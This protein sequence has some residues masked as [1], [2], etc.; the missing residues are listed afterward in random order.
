MKKNIMLLFLSDIKTAKDSRAVLLTRYDDVGEVAAT[1]ESAMRKLAADLGEERLDRLFV[2]ATDK[3][4]REKVPGMDISHLEFFWQRLQD[5]FPGLEKITAVIPYAAEA[6]MDEALH[7]VLLVAGELR[8][9]IEEQPQGDEILLHADTTGGMRHANMMIVDVLRLLEYSGVKV[10]HIYYSLYSERRVDEVNGIYDLLGVTSGAE[11]FV[12]FGSVKALQDYFT[13]HKRTPVI[14]ALLSA[15]EGFAEE[16]KLC[17]HGRFAAAVEKLRQALESFRAYCREQGDEALA[18]EELL[19]AQL[20]PRIYREYAPLL[21]GE[22]D[23]RDEVAWCLNHDYI[24]QAL[25]LYVEGIPDYLFGQ[26]AV[27]FTPLGEKAITR[28]WKKQRSPSGLNF[29][30]LTQFVPK[31]LLA[32]KD[33]GLGILQKSLFEK[34]AYQEDCLKK[35]RLALGKTLRAFMKC[36]KDDEARAL[37]ERMGET[38]KAA[39]QEDCLGV[40]HLEEGRD[41]LEE[42]LSW[43][44]DPAKLKALGAAEGG[45]YG[46]LCQAIADKHFSDW[47]AE[48]FHLSYGRQKLREFARVLTNKF[49]QDELL[50]MFFSVEYDYAYRFMTYVDSGLFALGMERERFRRILN[51]YGRVKNERNISN[52]ARRQ[53]EMVTA[54]EIKAFLSACLARM[55]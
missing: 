49:T 4:R 26:G 29:Y 15:M 48:K 7:N 11:E 16:V 19:L 20:L 23:I 33:A 42:W 18:S 44:Q 6:S 3:V 28:A 2:I 53:A 46:K 38:L 24:Q 52:H 5:K 12:N 45:F 35:V 30:A 14:A 37:L 13:S 32:D 34:N 55:R 21:E 17:H 27:A 40:S 41:W 54:G 31:H 50:D 25:T 39:G 36:E 1:N 43:L 8:R 47:Q 10:G 51:D 22:A 9:Y